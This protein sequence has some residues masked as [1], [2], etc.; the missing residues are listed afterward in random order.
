MRT[1]KAVLLACLVVVISGCSSW[2]LTRLPSP[3]E[4]RKSVD[5]LYSEYPDLDRLESTTGRILFTLIMDMPRAEPLVERWG[6]PEKRRLSWWGLMPGTLI[7][8]FHPTTVW[9][10]H[11]A[12]KR[13]RARIDHPLGYGWEAHVWT[14]KIDEVD[15]E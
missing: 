8:P 4:F 15:E 6:E 12:D 5:Q 7:P 13:V 1:G 11:M 9:T 2:E 14:V 10:W 3:S